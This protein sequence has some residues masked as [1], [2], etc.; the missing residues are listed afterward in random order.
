MAALWGCRLASGTG[1]VCMLGWQHCWQE[2]QCQNCISRP[3]DGP[4][5]RKTPAQ[6]L[7]DLL[8]LRLPMAWWPAC[9]CRG[10][11]GGYPK[12]P[13]GLRLM[14]WR[15][16][17]CPGTAWDAGSRAPQEPA[18]L[19][20]MSGATS[21]AWGAARIP[22]P[23]AQPSVQQLHCTAPSCHTVGIGRATHPW[24]W[25]PSSYQQ[26]AAGVSSQLA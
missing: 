11:W 8:S 5:P 25:S 6:L 22:S 13:C 18:V 12:K 1:T 15:P 19:T 23:C 24:G 20:G 14:R 2:K 4:A 10:A 21:T 3:Q 17:C 7:C 9:S 16:T 26:F